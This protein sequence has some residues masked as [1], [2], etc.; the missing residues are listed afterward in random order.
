MGREGRGK[1]GLRGQLQQIKAPLARPARREDCD[2][3]ATE[4]KNR[5]EKER[6]FSGPTLFS[7]K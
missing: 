1:K 6:L 3:W 4:R 2:L 5:K 7:V